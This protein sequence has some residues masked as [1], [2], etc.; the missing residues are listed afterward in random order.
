MLKN[1][2]KA[3]LLLAGL[4]LSHTASADIVWTGTGNYG[5]TAANGDITVSPEGGE[6]GYVSTSGGINQTGLGLGSETTGSTMESSLFNI[7]AGDDLSFY[8]NFITSDGAGFADYA[9][10]QL[11]TAADDVV[12][13]LFTAR[14]TPSGDTVPGFGMPL[15]TAILN[16]TSTPIIANETEFNM[17]GSSSGTCYS[18]GC[19]NTGWI[20]STYTFTDDGS[21]KL[22]M[23]V[24]NWNDSSY[25]T[26]LVFDNLEINDT[27]ITPP[28]AVGV[29]APA[30][31]FLM[32]ALLGVFAARRRK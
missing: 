19:G 6:F 16:P 12:A 7:V 14:S 3:L 22:L 32:A 2:K 31:G 24:T 5:F 21:Y 4:T 25:D 30:T 1:H 27:P 8:F 13:T 10:V 9:W 15:P 28:P 11:L 20:E 26:A 18:N 17:L 29:P 23:G